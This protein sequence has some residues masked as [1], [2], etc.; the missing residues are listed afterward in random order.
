MNRIKSLK[1]LAKF[2]S[3]IL[4]RNPFEFGLVPDK[5][6]YIKV[7]ELIKAIVEEEGW[8]HIKKSSLEE[9]VYSFPDSPI[10]I[11]E[12]MVRAKSR[13][14]YQK[15]VYAENIPKELY[16]AIRQKAHFH[17]STKGIDS[18]SDEYV[19][20]T[21]ELEIS[22]K[23]GKRKDSKPIILKINTALAEEAGVFFFKA[24]ENIFLAKYIP[25]GC[26]TGPPLPVPKNTNTKKSQKKT[27]DK[28]TSS[29][30]G[31]FFPEVENTIDSSAKKS[32]KRNKTSWKENK[33]KIRREKP[34]FDS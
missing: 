22:K 5:N 3:Y 9:L 27:I 28:K 24:Q 34:T 19:I 18:G 16:A 29:N 25:T 31:S 32:K 17:V 6:G 15:P 21:S 14:K 20:L 8:S 30:P 11:S 23:I 13:S 1:P 7:K 33:K 2:L 10:E 12:N 4:E 26:F